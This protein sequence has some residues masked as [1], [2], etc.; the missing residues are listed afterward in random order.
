MASYLNCEDI[1]SQIAELKEQNNLLSKIKELKKQNLL[2]M[3]ELGGY[4][5]VTSNSNNLIDFSSD[6]LKNK[7][8]S[9]C[10][11][12]S[13]TNLS[14]SFAACNLPNNNNNSL[15]AV[16]SHTFNFDV[17]TPPLSCGELDFDCSNNPAPSVI[18]IS[19]HSCL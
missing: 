9:V 3:K 1:L 10:D 14:P 2:L 19:T 8:S 4:S 17:Y 7:P 18:S 11:N 6:C 5:K 16:H 13:A 12:S 15:T